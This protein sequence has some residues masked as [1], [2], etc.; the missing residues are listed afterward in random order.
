MKAVTLL[1][2]SGN[3]KTYRADLMECHGITSLVYF[4]NLLFFL[5]KITSNSD[6]YAK[7]KYAKNMVKKLLSQTPPKPNANPV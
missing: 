5:T 6:L 7:L 3:F 1:L 2:T 4:L